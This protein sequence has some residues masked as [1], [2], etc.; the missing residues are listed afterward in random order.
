MTFSLAPATRPVPKPTRAHAASKVKRTSGQT[1]PHPP[2]PAPPPAPP[3]SWMVNKQEFAA[4]DIGAIPTQE[5]AGGSGSDSGHDKGAAYGPGEGPG[6][7]RL[8]NAEWYVEPTDAQL[9]TY[10]PKGERQSG[11]ADV[12]C[13]TIP[14]YGVE[15][16]RTLDESPI[17]SGLARAVR[18]A[19]WQFKI[20]PP[21]LGGKTLIGAWVRIHLPSSPWVEDPARRH[22]SATRCYDAEE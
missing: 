10:M 7:E 18:E 9:N 3:A 13:K 2:A 6:G 19:A 14:H 8:F 11:W 20:R 17:G 4:S 1:A 16:C 5:V 12:A 15:N 22:F 21:R